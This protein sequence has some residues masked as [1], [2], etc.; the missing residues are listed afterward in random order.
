MT[1]K[2][3]IIVGAGI[4]GLIAA[5]E[6]Q[7]QGI[8]CQ[9]F[10][11][12]ERPGGRVKTDYI[13]GFALDHGFQVLLTAY[14]ET[15]RYLDYEALR[16]GSFLPGAVIALDGKRFV[17]EDPLRRPGSALK[18]LASPIGSLKDKFRVLAWRQKVRRLYIDEIFAREEMTAREAL[19]HYG[20]SNS[21]IQHFW[22]PF[23][24]GIFLEK[25]L[26][27]SRRMMD[28]V[29]KMFTEGLATLPAGGIGQIPAQLL[30]E[31]APGSVSFEQPVI[32]VFENSLQTEDGQRHEADAILMATEATALVADY[33]PGI[34]TTHHTVKCI[35][36]VADRSPLTR[37]LLMLH[38]HRGAINNLAVLS[39]VADGYAPPHKALI[40][41]TVTQPERFSGERAILEQVR[42]ELRSMVG[43]VTQK[44][45]YLES[46][47]IRYALPRQRSV[48]HTLPA[49]GY[50]LSRSLF[51]CGDH[52]LNGSLNA[53]MTSGRMAS[54][55]V[56]ETLTIGT[57]Q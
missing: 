45:E 24:G 1:E 19:Q 50:Q 54:Q 28:F 33:M 26:S 35:Y 8:S 23:F 29:F 15:Q 7:Q 37:P 46:F 55:K 20:F 31:L 49:E 22:E 27:T 34:K 42:K 4:S 13:N 25:A 12:T 6:L 53:A 38:G 16:L 56:A 30:E 14:P 5:R 36:F 57:F 2:S 41:V 21:M 39:D 10:E 48:R 3:V 40:S 32:S 43:R 11:A 18:S 17:F 9:I 51:V 52:L 47:Y 44:W